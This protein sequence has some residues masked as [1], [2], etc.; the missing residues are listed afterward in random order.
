[1]A[2]VKRT[3]FEKSQEKL[4]LNVYILYNILLQLQLNQCQKIFGKV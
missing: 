4:A 2:E 1:M 3:N